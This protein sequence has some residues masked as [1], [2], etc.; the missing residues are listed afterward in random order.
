[1]QWGRF[2]QAAELSRRYVRR[3]ARRGG[4]TSASHEVQR[5]ETALGLGDIPE[6]RARRELLLRRLD[7][8]DD[9]P[10]REPPRRGIAVYHLITDEPDTAR[11]FLAAAIADLRRVLPAQLVR[12]GHLRILLAEA[13]RRTGDP[14]AALGSLRDALGRALGRSRFQSGLTG[15]LGAALVA[16]D[17]G[18]AA[19]HDLAAHWDAVRRPLGLPVPLGY[20]R[21]AAGLLGLDAA[22]PPLP[23]AGHPWRAGELHALVER[24]HSWC[25]HAT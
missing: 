10:E 13:Q 2:E 18:D 1:V 24:A 3:A 6:A 17:L 21:A 16:A 14:T 15:A 25:V 22:A 8:I 5:L 11:E 9:P 23:P 7:E 4:A 19:A 12:D 20:H